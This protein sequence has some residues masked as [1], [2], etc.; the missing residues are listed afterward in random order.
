MW[1][2]IVTSVR[3]LFFCAHSAADAYDGD[4]AFLSEAA[5]TLLSRPCTYYTGHCTGE[6]AYA[7]L[8]RRMGDRLHALRTGYAYV[9]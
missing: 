1:Y 3:G 4:A 2:N 7:F 8:K 6:A 5:Q 9:L